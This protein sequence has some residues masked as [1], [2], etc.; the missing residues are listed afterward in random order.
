M[1]VTQ[2]VIQPQ[3]A[4]NHIFPWHGVVPPQYCPKCGAS[5]SPAYCGGR[6]CLAVSGVRRR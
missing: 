6:G 4:C 2:T 5:L 3:V 1:D